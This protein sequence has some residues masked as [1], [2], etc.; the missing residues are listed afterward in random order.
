[1]SHQPVDQLAELLGSLS[2]SDPPTLPTLPELRDDPALPERWGDEPK[3]PGRGIENLL[4]NMPKLQ[5]K[6]D[7]QGVPCRRVTTDGEG[8][9][10]VQPR[11]WVSLQYID[12]ETAKDVIE[13][14]FV[15]LCREVPEDKRDKPVSHQGVVFKHMGDTPVEKAYIIVPKAEVAALE[16]QGWEV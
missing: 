10:R 7:S 16:A 13:N 14:E 8:T 11:R 15:T 9:V 1:M 12:Y 6:Y 4:A 5:E 3:N 2:L